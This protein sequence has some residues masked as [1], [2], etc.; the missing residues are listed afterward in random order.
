MP[1]CSA[2]RSHSHKNVMDIFHTLG[3]GSL[4]VT[5]MLDFSGK[6]NTSIHGLGEDDTATPCSYTWMPPSPLNPS[7]SSGTSAAVV[8]MFTRDLPSL[9]QQHSTLYTPIFTMVVSYVYHLTEQC[10]PRRLLGVQDWVGTGKCPKLIGKKTQLIFFR[11]GKSGIQV[12]WDFRILRIHIRV[13][14]GEYFV[15]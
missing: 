6:A 8:M 13:L 9:T 5:A 1:A 14:L 3:P 11:R 2:Q 15:D 12:F 4:S 7:L 10:C